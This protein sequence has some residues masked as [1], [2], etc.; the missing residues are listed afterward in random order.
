MVSLPDIRLQIAGGARVAL[1]DQMLVLPEEAARL[2]APRVM[3]SG[4]E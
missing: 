4:N 1:V 2:N 3:K